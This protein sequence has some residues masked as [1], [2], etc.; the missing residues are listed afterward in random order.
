M[1]IAIFTSVALLSAGVVCWGADAFTSTTWLW[2]LPVSALG[3]F[4]AELLLWFLLLVIMGTADKTKKQEEDSKL[5]RWVLHK[6]IDML[7]SLLGVRIHTKGFEQKL[8]EG[9]FMLVCNHLHDIDPVMLLRLFPKSQLAFI[10]KRE[11]EGMFLA[12]AFLKKTLGQFVN[13]ENDREALKSILECIRLIKEDKCSVAVFPEGYI[14]QDRLLRTFRPGVFKIAQK[15]NV[16]IVVCTLQD[17]HKALGSVMKLK[18][19]DIQLHLVG[20]LP[21]E[22]LVGVTTVDIAGRVYTMMAE[23]LG[24]DLVYPPENAE[25]T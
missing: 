2:L 1:L 22:E 23:D 18:G 15:A 12:G 7:L 10:G 4:L 24:P 11:V 13:R 3:T 25:N 8:P 5:Y 20:I 17:T 14:K 19:A 21:A 9:R 6:T 16:P